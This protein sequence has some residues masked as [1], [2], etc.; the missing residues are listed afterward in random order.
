MRIV[1][2]GDTH[3][4]HED[5][6]ILEGD[7]LIHC[8]D[9]CDGFR[10]DPGDVGNVDAWFAKQ[11]FEIILC[12]GGNHDFGVEDRIRHG[13]PVFQHAVWLLDEAVVH[14]GL[15]FYGSPWL[16]HLQG[17]A[18]Y[19]SSDGLRKKWSMIP[20]DTDVLITHTPPFGILDQPRS[21]NVNCGCAHL[22]ERVRE[23]KP[24]FHLFGH[25]HASAGMEKDDS[26][27]FVNASVVDSSLEVV[28]PAVTFDLPANAV[29]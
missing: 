26:T 9:F 20:D 25:N 21:R 2:I 10:K 19:Q 12:V 29:Q 18:F 17:W 28:R 13:E 1:V 22:L 6:G 27:T 8:G 15:K 7:V 11:R 24:Q 23:V 4:K 3:G 14:R 16:P 5:L